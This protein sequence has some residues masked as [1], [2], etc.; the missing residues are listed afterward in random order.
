MENQTV[1][2]KLP[3]L[4]VNAILQALS[5]APYAVAAPVIE[6]IRQQVGPQLA[7]TTQVYKEPAEDEKAGE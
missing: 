7:A 3:V 4:H 5:Q 6:T 2:L 1:D